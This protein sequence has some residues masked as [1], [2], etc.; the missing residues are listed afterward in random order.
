MHFLYCFYCYNGCV[1]TH[2]VEKT[3]A[4]CLIDFVVL[5]ESLALFGL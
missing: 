2:V 1:Q 3:D 4:F 5:N